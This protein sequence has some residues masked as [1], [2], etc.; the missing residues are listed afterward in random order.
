MRVV[1]HGLIHD[2]SMLMTVKRVVLVKR[3]CLPPAEVG[4]V[5]FCFKLFLRTTTFPVLNISIH[6]DVSYGGVQNGKM[7]KHKHKRG[8]WICHPKFRVRE[9]G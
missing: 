9:I 2:D 3:S 1:F 6:A 5:L 7:S 4:G 8:F